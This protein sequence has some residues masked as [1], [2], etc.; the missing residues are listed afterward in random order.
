MAIKR[1][2]KINNSWTE[3][4]NF[5]TSCYLLQCYRDSRIISHDFA[6]ES[7]FRGQTLK[8]SYCWNDL[9]CL[10]QLRKQ[11]GKNTWSST[12]MFFFDLEESC[13]LT[14]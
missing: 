11:R 10:L 6:N 5:Q 14:L 13:G 2:L 1:I 9:I 12:E 8:Q 4:F 3:L 7:I